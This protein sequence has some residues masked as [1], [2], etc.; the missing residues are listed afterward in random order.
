MSDG[1]VYAFIAVI[2]RKIEALFV[3]PARRAAGAGR[4]LVEYAIEELAAHGVDVN[5]QNPA[6][7]EF[8]KHLGFIV[9]ARSATDPHGFPILHMQLETARSQPTTI[10]DTEPGLAVAPRSGQGV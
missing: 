1:L 5:E 10:S 3:A 7:V 8:Y 9:V 4:R 2:D 6:A